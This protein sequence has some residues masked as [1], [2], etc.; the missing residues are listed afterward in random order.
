MS[1]LIDKRYKHRMLSSRL[2]PF[3]TS[4]GGQLVQSAAVWLTYLFFS[5]GDQKSAIENS[6]AQP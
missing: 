3:G 4:V 5:I 6:K 2:R 1:Y